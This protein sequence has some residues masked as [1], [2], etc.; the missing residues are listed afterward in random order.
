[1]EETYLS[2]SGRPMGTNTPS[3][4]ELTEACIRYPLPVLCLLGSG[5]ELAVR[6]GLLA[7]TQKPVYIYKG[8]AA[9]V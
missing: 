4:V 9:G 3:T 2:V 7:A 1:M 6:G 8:M 5:V